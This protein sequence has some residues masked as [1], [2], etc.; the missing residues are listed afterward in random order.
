MITRIQ[1]LNY[2]CLRHV[3]QQLDQFHMSSRS[4]MAREKPEILAFRFLLKMFFSG[5]PRISRHRQPCGSMILRNPV[6]RLL[7]S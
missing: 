2:R 7:Q 3:D 4:V 6:S 5:Q 1:A